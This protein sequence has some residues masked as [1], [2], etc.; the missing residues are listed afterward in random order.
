MRKEPQRFIVGD[1]F[2]EPCAYGD[3]VRYGDWDTVNQENIELR[4]KL[5]M[6]L[7]PKYGETKKL[8]YDCWKKGM[9]SREIQMNYNISRNS[10]HTAAKHLNLKFKTNKITKDT[11]P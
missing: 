9:S 4:K 2:A 1:G 10:I 3:F 7:N 6:R 5:G 8:V 11:L